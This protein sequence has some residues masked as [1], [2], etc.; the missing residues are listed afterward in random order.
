MGYIELLITIGIFFCMG[1]M[2]GM[3]LAF[4]AIVEIVN[5]LVDY[6]IERRDYF[7]SDETFSDED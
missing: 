6:L 7:I 1:I 5:G 4:N 3:L 2:V